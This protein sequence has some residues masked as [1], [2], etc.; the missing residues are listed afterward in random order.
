LGRV[1]FGSRR[2]MPHWTVVL[3][4]LAAPTTGSPPTPPGYD[5][6]L[7]ARRAFDRARSEHEAKQ[8]WPQFG[9]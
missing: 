5:S 8:L 1:N 3:Q 7:N 9:R 4:T 6:D 2:F